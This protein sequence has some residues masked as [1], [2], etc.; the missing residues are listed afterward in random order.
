LWDEIDRIAIISSSPVDGLT[1]TLWSSR[2]ASNNGK[3]KKI[4]KDRKYLVAWLSEEV[5]VQRR[6]WRIVGLMRPVLGGVA[7]VEL[8]GSGVR[9]FADHAEI[10]RA[11]A[12]FAGTRFASGSGEISR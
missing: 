6:W 3:K 11:L 8:S 5:V 9:L 1:Q 12:R 10:E 2:K 7:I 4:R